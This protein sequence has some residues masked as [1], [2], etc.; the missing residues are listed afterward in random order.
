MTIQH[1]RNKFT[2]KVYENNA[3]IALECH[4]LN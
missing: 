4:D 3:R 2:V 1:I